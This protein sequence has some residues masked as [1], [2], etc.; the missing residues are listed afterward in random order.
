MVYRRSVDFKSLA[1]TNSAT[2]AGIYKWQLY[3]KHIAATRNEIFIKNVDMDIHLFS[4][5][6]Y[7]D[8]YTDSI[9]YFV[10]NEISIN[11]RH[12]FLYER[13]DLTASALLQRIRGEGPQ[14]H[15]LRLVS[16]ASSTRE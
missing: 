6:S 2:P 7:N 11:N 15:P 3:H 9:Y 13:A 8:S 4:S 1:S 16:A 12:F 14:L 10:H 5:V